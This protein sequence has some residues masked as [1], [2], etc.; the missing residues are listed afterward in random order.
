MHHFTLDSVN[1]LM[2]YTQ[3]HLLHD[4]L[5]KPVDLSLS[6]NCFHLKKAEWCERTKRYPPNETNR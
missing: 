2:A 3:Q 4:R 6:D 5:Q 1:T